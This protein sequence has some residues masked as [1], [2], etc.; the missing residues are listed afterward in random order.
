MS[1]DEKV[2]RVSVTGDASGLN[3]EMQKTKDELNKTFSDFG[4][5]EILEKAD[6]KFD[7]MADKIRAVKEELQ[8][9]N[10]RSVGE[11]ESRGEGGNAA[12]QANIRKQQKSY[13]EQHEMANNALDKFSNAMGGRN[14]PMSNN[15][16]PNS[17]E[18]KKQTGLLERI[19]KELEQLN[20]RRDE[21][22]TREEVQDINRNIEDRQR[23]IR[24]LTTDTGDTPERKN[25]LQ[26]LMGAIKG[27][28]GGAGGI[29][30]VANAARGGSAGSPTGAAG[31]LIEGIGNGTLAAGGV[32]VIIASVIAKGLADGYQAMKKD[33]DIG[34]VLSDALSTRYGYAGASTGM[35]QTEFMDFAYGTAKSRGGD[36]N[37]TRDATDRA[38]LKQAYGLEDG[39]MRQFDKFFHS[40]GSEAST[41][42]A[43]ILK[44]SESKGIL[45]VDRG[46]FSRIPQILEQVSGLMGMQKA[47][48]E[49][50]NE[51]FAI[52]MALRGQNI[53]G[54]FADDRLGEVM[55]RINNSIQNPSNGGMRAYIF[56]M[57]K[58]ANPNA[59][60]TDVLGMQENGASGENLQAILP[61]IANMK[62]GEMRRMVL[63]QLTK[64]WQDAIRLDSADNLGEMMGAAKSLGKSQRDDGR[65]NAIQK[66]AEE[67]TPELSKGMEGAKAAW[68]TWWDGVTTSID[69]GIKELRGI[70]ST[71]S[72][73]WSGGG[74]GNGMPIFFNNTIKSNH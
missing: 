42:I 51:G 48:G 17:D 18:P 12:Y 41:I 58:R 71:K 74:V 64:N 38:Y 26:R 4:L 21:A 72:V 16:P 55:G 65:F 7:N 1:V 20:K 68:N 37:I 59:S 40:G 15:T 46:D 53:G 47:S 11:L 36:Q 32:L 56:E 19:R 61:Q 44:R 3:K 10:E 45:G 73:I 22:S 2:V 66:R 30:R 8:E 24:D 60:Y 27:G 14:V 25:I 62:Q 5:D 57:L 69:E 52:E 43:D 6:K 54:R 13:E 50:V 34:R 63:Y 39:D 23:Q 33:M 9:L 29:S 49:K 35:S 28:E 67:L 31:E 70:Q